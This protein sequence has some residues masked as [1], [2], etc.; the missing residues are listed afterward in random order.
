M[1]ASLIRYIHRDSLQKGDP[2]REAVR[3][4][5]YAAEGEFVPPLHDRRSTNQGDLAPREL[6]EKMKEENLRCY[7][8]EM[9]SQSVVIAL[10]GNTPVGFLS[11]RRNMLKRVGDVMMSV[12]YISTIVVGKEYREQHVGNGLYDALIRAC[13]ERAAYLTRTWETNGAHLAILE[14][15]CF[16][17][18]E[19]V[20]E[21]R[22]ERDGTP[23]ATVYCYRKKDREK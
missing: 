23:V 22:K 4:L 19:T 8:R 12:H 16:S 17:I 7:F 20:D 1:D 18:V 21:G 14:S 11:Y 5:L 13:G 3:G 9:A 10:A 2:Y 15:H 6:T